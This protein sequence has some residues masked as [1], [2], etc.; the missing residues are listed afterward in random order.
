MILIID[1]VNVILI[2]L[3]L[4][5]CKIMKITILNL[6]KKEKVIMEEIPVRVTG[7]CDIAT[8][9]MNRYMAL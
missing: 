5:Y 9:H 4:K 2:I 7:I 1:I 3:M 8:S 6:K